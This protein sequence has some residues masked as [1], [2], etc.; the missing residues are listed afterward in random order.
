MN[1]QY[2]NILKATTLFGGVQGLNIVLNLVRTKFV[3]ELLGAEGIGLNSIYNETR[4]L[5]HSTSNLGLDV[6]GVRG[7]SAAYEKWTEAGSDEER[8]TCRRNISIQVAVLRSWVLLLALVGILACMVF[9]APLS[10]FTFGDYDHTWGF[11]MLS[12][13]VGFSTVTCGELAVLKGLRKLR[14]LA[15]VS[16]LNVVTGIAVTIP[17]YYFWR[18]DGVLPAILAFCLA[19]MIQ[20]VAFG[21]EAERFRLVFTKT[22]LRKGHKALSVGFNFVMCSIIGHA[23]LLCIQAYL[24]NHASLKTVGFY[25]AGYT[26]TMTYVGLVLAAM[27][28]D[29]F[30]RLS[31]VIQNIKERTDILLKQQDVTIILVT[32]M[33]AAMI[34]ALPLVAPLLLSAKFACIVPMAQV[35]TIGMLFRAIYLPNAYMSL[36][37]GDNKTFLLINTFGAVDSMLVLAGYETYGLFGTGVALTV[38]NL[39]DMILVMCISRWKYGVG[40]S[41]RRIADIVIYTLF[42]SVIY[43]TCLC[44]EGWLYWVCGTSMTLL[45]SAYSILK[46]RQGK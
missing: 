32:P 4:E 9:A 46:F 20:T 35:A 44:T 27:E 6:S 31:G 14:S 8:Q 13:A 33:L 30:P 25:N 41:A 38:Q 45:C 43:I 36:A 1:L 29:Y 26:L 15:T 19:A 11:V 37:A 22:E 7:V 3:A 28:T 18:I 42:L 34:V 40:F 17:M 12:P 21:N 23:A 5:I 16:T 24:N 10:Y 39:M 2:K